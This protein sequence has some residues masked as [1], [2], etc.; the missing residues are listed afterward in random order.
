MKSV[1]GPRVGQH[2]AIRYIALMIPYGCIVR[3]CWP[4]GL[5]VRLKSSGFVI[6][7]TR[8]EM[9]KTLTTVESATSL[10]VTSAVAF[11]SLEVRILERNLLIVKPE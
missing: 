2:C 6:L 11:S 10:G 4:V 5:H 9:T 8:S 7:R 1:G 3:L